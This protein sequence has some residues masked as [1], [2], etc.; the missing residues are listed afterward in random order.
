MESE[1]ERRAGLSVVW[2][3]RREEMKQLPV[4]SERLS[5]I[6]QF[7]PWVSGPFSSARMILVFLQI[8]SLLINPE[9][10]HGDSCIH[11]G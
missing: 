8:G 4:G 5:H 1:R 6:G 3:G 10:R 9:G 11:Q 2:V 7:T